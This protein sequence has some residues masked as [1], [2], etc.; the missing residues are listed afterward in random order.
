MNY[1]VKPNP[2]ETVIGIIYFVLQLLILPSII[3]VGNMLLANPLPE[4]TVQVL[5]FAVN[6][7]AVLLIFRKFL[8]ANFRFLLENHT[9]A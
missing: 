7:L 4:T 2:N 8:V 9:L 5:I 6:F 3:L 1:F